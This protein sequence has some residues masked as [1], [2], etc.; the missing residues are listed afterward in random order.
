MKNIIRPTGLL[1]FAA[2]IALIV[3]FWF[4]AADW[5]LKRTIEAVGSAAVGAKVELDGADLSLSPFGVSLTNLQVTDPDN[6]MRN[7]VQLAQVDAHVALGKLLM[8]QVIVKDLRAEGVRLDTARTSTGAIA[9]RQKGVKTEQVEADKA[10][11]DLSALQEELPSA[12]EILER[13]PLSTL[14]LSD[15]FKQSLASSSDRVGKSLADLPDESDFKQYQRQIDEIKSGK[16][17]SVEDLKKRKA[18]LDDLKKSIRQDKAALVSARETVS[19]AKADLGDRFKQLK[20]APGQD[21][22]TLKNKYSFSSDNIGNISGLLF[23]AEAKA[24]IEKIRPWAAQLQK[25]GGGAETK[26]LPPPP[27]G[28]GRFISFPAAENLPDVLVRKAGLSI[29]TAAGNVAV[30]L[31]D[32]THQPHILGRPMGLKAVADNLTNIGLLRVNGSFDHAD[33][34]AATDRLAWTVEQWQLSDVQLSGSSELALTIAQARSQM[35][36]E[37]VLSNGELSGKVDSNFAEVAWL[38]EGEKSASVTK[39][40]SAIEQFKVAADIGGEPL[41]PRF[42]LH[43]DLDEKLKDNFLSKIKQRQVEL[44]KELRAKL[45]AKIEQVAAPYHD[46]LREVN[47]REGEIKQR[48]AMAEEMLKAEVEGAID[49]KKEEAKDKLKDKL[50]RLKF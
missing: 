33:P 37:L 43:S 18:A 27:R 29:V 42:K 4:F 13:E 9:G 25:L 32:V 34:K 41:S 50:K 11:I 30:E 45:E 6:P 40:L 48:L 46:G 47:K 21:L 14:A 16:I 24:W 17:S 49:S 23:G 20:N 22:E 8:G 12:D 39:I 35:E 10:A 5:L 31:N 28:E 2:I 7:L 26:E 19:S 3:L 1:G 38:G 15:E 36:G 44:E